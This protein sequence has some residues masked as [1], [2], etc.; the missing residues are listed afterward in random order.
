MLKQIG[1][2]RSKEELGFD[3]DHIVNHNPSPIYF[4]LLGN[5]IYRFTSE[6]AKFIVMALFLDDICGYN[7]CDNP[8]LFGQLIQFVGFECASFILR[9]TLIDILV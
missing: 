9:N 4:N 1:K 8:G 5:C 2:G 3:M 6:L 7:I